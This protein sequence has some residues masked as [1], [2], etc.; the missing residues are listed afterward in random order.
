MVPRKKV[1][2]FLPQVVVHAAGMRRLQ[3]PSP[4]DPRATAAR[5]ALRGA[6][7]AARTDPAQGAS[8]GRDGPS[9]TRGRVWALVTNARPLRVYVFDGG[10][11]PFGAPPAALDADRDTEPGSAGRGAAPAPAA[12]AGADLI[13]NLWRLDRSQARAPVLPSPLHG[14]CM[15]RPLG[16]LRL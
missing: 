2:R 5:T 7:R 16:M 15:R 1:D 11:V 6:A 10:V 14:M 4:G 8:P 3:L 9:V 13:V 12:N